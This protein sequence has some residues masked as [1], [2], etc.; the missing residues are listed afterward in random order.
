MKNAAVPT[1]VN[2]TGTVREH[3]GPFTRMSTGCK[4]VL[5]MHKSM[6]HLEETLCRRLLT[7][8]ASPRFRGPALAAPPTVHSSIY[9]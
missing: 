7:G 9:T 6:S 3:R 4:A 2:N 1:A 5:D 8:L